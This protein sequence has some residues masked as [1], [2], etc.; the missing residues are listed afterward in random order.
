MYSL[1][2]L[3]T[4]TRLGILPLNELV[5]TQISLYFFASPTAQVEEYLKEVNKGHDDGAILLDDADISLG[6]LSFPGDNVSQDA[7]TSSG[8]SDPAI[9]FGMPSFTGQDD[10]AFMNSQLMG[11]GMS[12]ALP[13]YEMIEEL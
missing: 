7:N 12:E 3:A 9:A 5:K 2:C 6:D 11:L 10:S 8:A 1:F 13:P 4:Y